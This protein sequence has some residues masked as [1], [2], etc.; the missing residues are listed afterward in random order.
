VTAAIRE[1]EPLDDVVTHGFPANQR[2][3]YDAL[4]AGLL[5]IGD[6]VCSF[7]PLYGMGMTVAVLEAD[8]LRRCPDRYLAAIR[9]VI[10]HAW[11][12]AVG[13][14]LAL[15]EVEGP[16]PARVRAIGAYVGRL[17]RVAETDPVV[18]R[19]FLDVVAMLRPPQSLLRP[20]IARRVV[21]A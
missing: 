16:R 6:A 8:A 9:P 3:H 19:A 5:P 13:G 1:A 11:E 4:P 15:P 21:T 10:D 12:M 20:S 2:R 7:N 14:D 18:A 17:Q